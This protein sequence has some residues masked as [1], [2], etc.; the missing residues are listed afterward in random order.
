MPGFTGLVMTDD[1]EGGAILNVS[2]D[3]TKRSRV[4]IA[5]GNGSG[6]DL[7]P[8]AFGRQSPYRVL[9]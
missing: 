9:Q 3:S 6:D 4:A 2:T 1:L 7:A 8:R 5:A